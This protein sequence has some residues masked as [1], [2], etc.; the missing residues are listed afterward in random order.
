M[1]RKSAKAWRAWG[2]RCGAEAMDDATRQRLEA[3]EVKAAFAEDLLDQLNLTIYRQHQQIEQLQQQLG[4]LRQQ[5]TE[6]SASTRSLRDELPP[7][8]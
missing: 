7:H 2:K 5:L 4:M 8:Y 3:L 6:A 1:W